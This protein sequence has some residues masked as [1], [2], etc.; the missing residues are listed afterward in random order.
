MKLLN[1]FLVKKAYHVNRQDFFQKIFG[2]DEAGTGTVTFQKSDRNHNSSKVGTEPYK[3]VTVPQHWICFELLVCCQ[4]PQ[5][6][7]RNS[8]TCFLCSGHAGEDGDDPG[9]DRPGGDQ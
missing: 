8:N 5:M 1:C 6:R 3:I 4:S 9:S 2:L 7:A